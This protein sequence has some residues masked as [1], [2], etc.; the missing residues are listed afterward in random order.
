M[1]LE[2]SRLCVQNLFI[3]YRFNYQH[4]WGYLHNTYKSWHKEDVCKLTSAHSLVGESTIATKKANPYSWKSCKWVFLVTLLFYG[5]LG[6]VK[7]QNQ[8]IL[9]IKSKSVCN[10]NRIVLIV[11]VVY[12]EKVGAKLKVLDLGPLAF[13]QDQET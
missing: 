9:F 13:R 4:N 2:K 3:V 12:Q 11:C 8:A 7:V 5:R 6:Y 10:A 1:C